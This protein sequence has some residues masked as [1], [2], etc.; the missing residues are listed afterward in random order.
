[1]GAPAMDML[2]IL[3]HGRSWLTLSYTIHSPQKASRHSCDFLRGQPSGRVVN[4][5]SSKRMNLEDDGPQWRLLKLFVDS[6]CP[7]CTCRSTG[8]NQAVQTYVLTLIHFQQ[9]NAVCTILCYTLERAK[10]STSD[11]YT[12]FHLVEEYVCG[13]HHFMVH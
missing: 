11:Q 8:C 1:M 9:C 4:I 13:I 3:Q 12:T 5:R 6:F 2:T 7:H 10:D